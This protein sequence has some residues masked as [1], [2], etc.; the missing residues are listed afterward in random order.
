MADQLKM[1]SLKCANYGGDLEIYGDMERFA[2]GYCGSEQIVERRGGTIGLRLVV[3]A[4]A[5]VQVGT[6]KTAAEL[7]LVRLD[8][9]L[10]TD[11]AQW[12]EADRQFC[13]RNKSNSGPAVVMIVLSVLACMGALGNFF[14]AASG[15]SGV[16][17]TGSMFLSVIFAG[18]AIV[19]FILALKANA[20]AQERHTA[21][22]AEL[23]RPHAKH[24]EQLEMQIGKERRL[25]RS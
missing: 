1:V 18:G 24:I 10:A 2:C 25:I 6:D 9:E 3:D 13:L 21:R 4:V 23:S 22:R 5:R 19:V 8:K 15:A 12:Q 16:M 7:A 11:R 17:D 20:K 14:D